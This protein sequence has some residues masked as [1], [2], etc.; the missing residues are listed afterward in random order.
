VKARRLLSN[1][2]V[3]VL[4]AGC[5]ASAPRPQAELPDDVRRLV[6]LLVL[7]RDQIADVRTR[8]EI[9]L[10]RGASTQRFAG[11]LLVRTPD[12]VR[13]EAL[14]PFGPP[15]LLVT[16]ADGTLTTYSVADHR[17]LVGPATAATT[18]RWLGLSLD[19]ADLVGL[20]LGRVIPPRDLREAE[21]LPADLHGRSVRLVGAAQ[22]RRVWMDFETGVIGRVEIGGGRR[23][24]TVAYDRADVD[25]VPRAL[26]VATDRGDLEGDLRYREPTVSVGIDP[27]L[28]HFEIPDGANVQRFH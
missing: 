26:H 5:A 28:F 22:T 13:F 20:L 27:A 6:A 9:T 25:G 21:I 14:S 23:T 17:A 18:S 16:V 24:L 8:V 12:A 15:F 4:V 2:A 7:R 1:A 11:A 10:R 3:A 19:P